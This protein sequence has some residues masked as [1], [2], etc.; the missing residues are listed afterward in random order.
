MRE[1]QHSALVA[2][3]AARLFEIINDIESYPQF[4]PWCTH[5]RV[6]SRSERELVATLGMRRGPLSG[7]FTTRNELE[8]YR[9][10][11]M[12]LVDGPFK[13]LEGEWLLLPIA[14]DSTHAVEGCRVQLSMKFAFKDRLTSLLLERTFAATTKSLVDAFVAR[15]RNLGNA[16]GASP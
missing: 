8:P 14:P 7:E 3:P 13:M 10:I 4:I 6:R 15:A 12:H 1:I 2:Q 11:R 5:A 16:P 9:R